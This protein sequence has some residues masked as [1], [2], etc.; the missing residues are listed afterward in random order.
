MRESGCHKASESDDVA[1]G[2]DSNRAAGRETTKRTMTERIR[3][4]R[5]RAR[6][7]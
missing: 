4:L 2:N 5:R 6:G 7:L 1:K 3:I